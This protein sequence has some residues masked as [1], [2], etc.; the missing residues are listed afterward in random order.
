M[1]MRSNDHQHQQ[2]ETNDQVKG[3]TRN[4]LHFAG[5]VVYLFALVV[6]FAIAVTLMLFGTGT[7]TDAQAANSNTRVQG[8]QARRI[9]TAVSEPAGA[10]QHQ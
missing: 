10:L 6:F 8:E 5:I 2:R 4:E 3:F 9:D 7:V 1:R